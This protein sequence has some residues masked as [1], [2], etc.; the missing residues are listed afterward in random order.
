MYVRGNS[1]RCRA[2]TNYSQQARACL[3]SSLLMDIISTSVIQVWK[4]R[5]QLIRFL[6]TEPSAGQDRWNQTACLGRSGTDQG[7]EGRSGAKRGACGGDVVSNEVQ[8]ETACLGMKT[9]SGTLAPGSGGRR[10]A[11]AGQ[12]GTAVRKVELFTLCDPPFTAKSSKMA[13][14][15]NTTKII[16]ILNPSDVVSCVLVSVV[17]CNI[18][19]THPSPAL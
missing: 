18:E 19:S 10:V 14:R 5:L 4:R 11:I 9:R 17:Y 6:E 16:L 1:M 3:R 13:A 12:T 7:R 2:S 15:R 8:C